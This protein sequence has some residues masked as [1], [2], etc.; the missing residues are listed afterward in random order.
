MKKIK[1]HGGKISVSRLPHEKEPTPVYNLGVLLFNNQQYDEAIV[2]FKKALELNPNLINA[3][4][5]LGRAFNQKK[6]FN[7][8]IAFFQKAIQI[9]PT[10]PTAYINLGILLQ[11]MN[12]HEKAIECFRA[13]LR[14][15]PNLYQAYDYLGLLLTMDDNIE[16]AVKC[17]Q[18]S[19]V[20]NPNSEMALANL[21]NLIARQ[22][23][24]NEAVNYYQRALQIN[25]NNCIAHEAFLCNLSYNAAYNEQTIFSEHF[26][27]AK[28]FAEPLSSCIVP[29]NNER[30]SSR[31]LRIGYVSADFKRHPVANFFEPILAAH[32]RNYFE[33]FCYSNVGLCDDIS[34]R[35]KHFTDQ[36][37]DISKAS[38]YKAAE[39]I[40][41]DSIDILIDLSGH[42]TG[43]RILLFARK[44]APVQVTW[45]GYLPTTGLSTIDYKIVDN[46]TDPPGMT[47]RFYAE[48][49]MRLPES[50]V[51]YLPDG[52]SPDVGPLPALTKGYITFGSF[53][54]F[55]KVTPQVFELWAKILNSVPS[56]RLMMKSHIF[57]DNN[58]CQ[59]ATDMFVK[60]GIIGDRIILQ[61][62]DPSPKHLDSYNLV[63]IG[64][65]TF[66][67]NGLTTSC[68]ALWMGVPVITLAGTCYASRAGVSV[69]SNLGLKELIAE[70][71]DE[72][73]SIAVNLARDLKRLKSLREHLRNI[74]TRSPLCDAKRFTANLEMCYRQI[75]E[76]W[77]KAL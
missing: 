44:P 51:C 42:T 64:L 41:K 11:N 39:A 25:P 15:I 75:W 77:C 4:N 29:Y 76:T 24:L 72:Y 31:K 49:L 28:K 65:D 14:F 21:G 2:N 70:T 71:P 16:E 56:S 48:K 26:R 45:I 13:A 66:P 9:N 30:I 52:Q 35:I 32:N 62:A 46:Y 12:Q 47:D 10:D 69:L 23:K 3:Y 67:F 59:Y 36:W 50:F 5:Y 17:Y 43:N 57:S 74:M 7:E 37:R 38:D 6:Q 19:L 34:E 20:I 40:R 22:G 73:I 63:D 61:S 54:N 53:N 55:Q 60:R 8:A 68:E 33:V 18:S 27:W 1:K 58:T